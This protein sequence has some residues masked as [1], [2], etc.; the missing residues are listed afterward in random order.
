MSSIVQKIHEWYEQSPR[1]QKPPTGWPTGSR[2][3]TCAAQLQLLRIPDVSKPEPFRSRA[4]RMFEQGDRIEAWLG[5]RLEQCYPNLIGLRQELFYFRVGLAREQQQELADRVARR[6]LW[7]RVVEQFNEPKLWLGED[8][9]VK[10]RLV[11]RTPE[12]KPQAL[13]FVVDLERQCVWVPTYIDFAVKHEAL[14]LTIVEAKSMSDYAFRRTVLGR[15]DYGKQ[16]QLVGFARATGANVV[17]VAYR[18][19]TS[20]LCEVAYVRGQERTR[21]VL[22][23]PNGSQEVYWVDPGADDKTPLLPEAGGAARSFPADLLWETAETWTPYNPALEAAI[24]QRVR[25]V[26]LFEGDLAKLRREAGPDFTCP[27]C[28]GTGLQVNRKG[29]SVPLQ[30]PKP[31]ETC[32][33]TGVLE[34]TELGAF[35]CGYC[36][37]VETCWAPAMPRFEIDDRPHRYIRRDQWEMSGLTFQKPEGE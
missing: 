5:E 16:C 11:P 14:G 19:Q 31:C 4:L 22:T 33:Q 8:G 23:A 24:D 28:G 9:R 6:T 17:L 10:M 15:L 26:L 37:V 29:S 30:K 3:G 35:P 13:G 25:D 7:G 36:A 12:G 18:N 1:R 34:E 2:L 32:G 27:T 21:V 20:H